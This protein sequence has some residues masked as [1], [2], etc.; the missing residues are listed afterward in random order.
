[1]AT[2]I[3]EYQKTDSP[4]G[5]HIVECCGALTAFNYK[6][7]DECQE[8]EKLMTIEAIHI[9]RRKPQLNTRDESKS[10]ELTLKH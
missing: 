4:V 8:S 6:I 1:M 5:Q 9:S 2:R 7:I 10:R 3:S